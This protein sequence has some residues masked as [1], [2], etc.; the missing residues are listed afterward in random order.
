[1]SARFVHEGELWVFSEG[2]EEMGQ[3]G[4]DPVI[5]ETGPLTRDY[6]T[7]L[8]SERLGLSERMEAND[9]DPTGDLRIGR[10]GITVKVLE[11]DDQLTLEDA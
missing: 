7:A 4:F 3:L 2:F 6:L 10:V 1:M 8:V 5:V 9:V 11:H